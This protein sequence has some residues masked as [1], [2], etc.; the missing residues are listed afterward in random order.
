MMSACGP[1]ADVRGLDQA[2]KEV[3]GGTFQAA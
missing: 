1:I 3:L 2:N